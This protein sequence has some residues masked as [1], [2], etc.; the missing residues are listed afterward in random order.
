MPSY[1]KYTDFIPLIGSPPDFVLYNV[2]CDVFTI[3]PVCGSYLN[4]CKINY[5]MI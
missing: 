1:K 5:K 3:P 2:F 4:K